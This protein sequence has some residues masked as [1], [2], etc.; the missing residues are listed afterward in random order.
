M[1]LPGQY[2]DLSYHCLG[3]IKKP[4]NEAD[5]PHFPLLLCAVSNVLYPNNVYPKHSLRTFYLSI[6][7]FLPGMASQIIF[8]I[9]IISFRPHLQPSLQET[10]SPHKPAAVNEYLHLLYRAP[11][12][13]RHHVP[14]P[15]RG[16]WV[17]ALPMWILPVATILVEWMS[18]VRSVMHSTG[19]QIVYQEVPSI[20]HALG[21]A[22]IVARSNY[23]YYLLLPVISEDC[24]VVWMNRV[25][26]I[27]ITFSNIIRHSPSL[28]SVSSRMIRSM[29][30]LAPNNGSSKSVVNFVTK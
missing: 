19:K 9:T 5:D 13:S 29:N 4:V 22:A 20:N 7:S 14:I 24:T 10:S 23:L 21:S 6:L 27:V 8:A 25:V 12:N 30:A 2:M 26:N 17:L 1:I 15:L 16:L 28:R 18:D 11:R 3:A